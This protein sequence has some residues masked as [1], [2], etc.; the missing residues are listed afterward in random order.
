MP[1]PPRR[2]RLRRRPLQIGL[3]RVWDAYV[4][5]GALRQCSPAKKLKIQVMRFK[6]KVTF[7]IKYCNLSLLFIEKHIKCCVFIL[8]ERG[9]RVFIVMK[10]DGEI[11]E[12]KLVA[13]SKLR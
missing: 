3:L 1:V 4:I 11:D 8:G 10:I 12:K 9:L 13:S 5:K 7:V 6:V 2:P